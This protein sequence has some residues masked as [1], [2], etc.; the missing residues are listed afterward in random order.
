MGGDQCL[1]KTYIIGQG[2]HR[3]TVRRPASLS[4]HRGRLACFRGNEGGL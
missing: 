3:V 2:Y 1:K 4:E